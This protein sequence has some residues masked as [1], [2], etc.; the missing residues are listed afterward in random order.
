MDEE[1]FDRFMRYVNKTKDCWLWTGALDRE[2][3]YGQFGLAGKTE[4][5][6]R[7]IW[8]HCYGTIDDGLVVRH[9][10]RN[11]NCCNPDHLELGTQAQ[12]SHDKIRDGTTN[13]GEKHGMA[14]LTANQV[15]QIRARAMEF[16]SILVQEFGISR[17]SITD[18][19]N[20][21]TWKHV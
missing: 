19:I 14:K 7:L 18:I 15:L 1:A 2:G 8:L 11:R 10:C 21:I 12:N 3:G 16:P 6:H 17:S 5:T 9:Q 20:R 4:Y 13:R